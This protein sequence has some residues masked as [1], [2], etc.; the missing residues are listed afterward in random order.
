MVDD[1]EIKYK[2]YIQIEEFDPEDSDEYKTFHEE[3]IAGFSSAQKAA[4]FLDELSRFAGEMIALGDWDC[5]DKQK[6][7]CPESEK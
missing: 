4:S 7:E 2:I 3:F 6:A 5:D 1:N